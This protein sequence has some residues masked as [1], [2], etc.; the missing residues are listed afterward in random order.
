MHTSA[1]KEVEF[2]HTKLAEKV[3]AGHVAVFPLEAVT[4]IK[5]LWLLPVAV[6]TQ[7]R[8][9]PRMIYDFTWSGLNETSKCLS[10]MEAMRSGVRSSASSS[11]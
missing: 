7:V 11:R 8:R 3:Q 10:P 4:S 5:N 1:C 6:I 9:I 2:I